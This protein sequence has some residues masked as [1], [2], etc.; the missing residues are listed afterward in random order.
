M[1]S[2]DINKRKFYYCLFEGSEDLTDMGG[3]KTGEKRLVYSAPVEMLANVSEAKGRSEA[4]Q[5]GTD[6]KY[7]KVILTCEMDCPINEQTVLFVD[8]EP[9]FDN[10]GCPLFDYV[11]SRVA[12]SI[13][14]ITY[15]IRKVDVTGYTDVM[16]S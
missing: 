14:V 8:R 15:A 16:S 9:A 2:Q 7:D 4:E 6:L 12:K 11:V 3:Y 13:N 10:D 1:L 5:F